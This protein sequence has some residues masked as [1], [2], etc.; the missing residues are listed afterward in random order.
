[1]AWFGAGGRF[2]NKLY[3]GNLSSRTKEEDL[4]GSFSKYGDVVDVVLKYDFAFVEFGN[5][6]DMEEAMEWVNKNNLIILLR[7][8]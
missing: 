8:W 6:K 4:R 2:Q 3:V 5:D 1:M 7:T